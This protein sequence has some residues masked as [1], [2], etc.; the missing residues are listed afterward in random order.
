M[1]LSAALTLQT[2]GVSQDLHQQRAGTWQV[3]L[4]IPTGVYGLLGLN[5]VPSRI[6]A[7]SSVFT[8]NDETSGII[9]TYET[10]P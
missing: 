2:Q 10:A 1:R 5:D 8:K 9:V 6:L 7:T 4:P 3:T